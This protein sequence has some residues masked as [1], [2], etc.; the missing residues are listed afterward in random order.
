MECYPGQRGLRAAAG[1]PPIQSHTNRHGVG[2]N[3]Q[4]RPVTR[5]MTAGNNTAG[6]SGSGSGRVGR[7]GAGR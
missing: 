7:S 4:P 5:G 6:G 1:Y 3:N 2:P